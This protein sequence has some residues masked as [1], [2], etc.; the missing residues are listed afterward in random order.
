[1]ARRKT[2][3]MVAEYVEQLLFYAENKLFMRNEDKNLARN[4]IFE[5]LQLN[6]MTTKTD[7]EPAPATE[8]QEILQKVVDYAMTKGIIAEDDRLRFETKIMGYL[9]PAPSTVVEMFDDYAVDQSPER[10]CRWLYNLEIANNYI[11]VPDIRKNIKWEAENPRGNLAITINLAKPEKTPEQIAAAANAPT[12][13]YPR[14]AL[15]A[16]NVGFAGS[17]RQAAR[18]TL[19]TI[20]LSLNGEDW[21]FQFSPYVYF[22]QHCLAISKEH[23][24]M[25]LGRDTFLRFLDFLDCFPHY[26]IGSNA[27]LPIVGGSILAH[28]HYQGGLKVLPMMT[29]KSRAFYKS[30]VFSD[31]NISVVDWYNSVVRL[32]SQ[33]RAQLVNA[34]TALYEL[35]QNYDNEACNIISHTGDTPHNTV[36][37]IARINDNRE[38]CFDLI[39]RNNRTD[40]KHPFGI[41]HPTEDMHNIKKEGIGIIEVMGLFILPGRLANEATKIKDYLTGDTELDFQALADPKNP[42]SAHISTIAQLTNDYGTKC[43]AK[44]AGDYVV[45]YINDTCAKILDCTAVFKHDEQGI[46]AF[47]DFMKKFTGDKET[48]E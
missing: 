24:P 31:V 47:D 12:T 14:C 43:S 38:F 6:E 7:L 32:E 18:Q 28:E 36:T 11:R 8:F 22:E 34:A 33:N 15:C 29:A 37:P 23:R 45:Q 40:E 46:A 30:D 13:N 39:L 1:M 19:R 20:P 35:W 25:K 17:A 9:T 42:M 41:F 2:S 10:A 48:A 3:D 4:N 5:A 26:F 27:C 16:E 44:A 21:F